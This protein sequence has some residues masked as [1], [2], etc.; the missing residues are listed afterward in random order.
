MRCRNSLHRFHWL[1][2]FDA[3]PPLITLEVI[4]LAVEVTAKTVSAVFADLG[5]DVTAVFDRFR[6]AIFEEK[7]ASSS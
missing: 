3:A 5:V 2:R 7:A 4:D 6:E 1:A